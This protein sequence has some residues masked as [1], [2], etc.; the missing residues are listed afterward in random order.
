[1]VLFDAPPGTSCPVV[2]TIADVDYVVL[3]AEPT[4]FGLHDLSLMV[5]LLS[6]VKKPHG[7]IINKAGIGTKDIYTYLEE[8]NVEIL[9]EIPFSIP[10]A[11]AYSSGN[12]LENFP[13]DI[14]V[15]FEKTAST[16]L[17]KL[18]A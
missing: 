1:L 14:F 3:V 18:K 11:E 4:P 12:L 16:L 13:E 15:E 8:K 9:G 10:L 2:E 6:E 5:D 7:V 17:S